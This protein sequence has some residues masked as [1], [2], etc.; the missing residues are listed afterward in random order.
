MAVNLLL[1]FPTAR[2]EQHRRVGARRNLRR[3]YGRGVTGSTY[4][5]ERYAREN[6]LL[7]HRIFPYV[8]TK[9]MA[10][11]KRDATAE[12]HAKSGVRSISTVLCRY[13]KQLL[14]F[15]DFCF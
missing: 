3:Y 14:L 15:G 10:R 2:R 7:F 4:G 11:P 1:D 12:V 13:L 8:V 5:G 6:N 9:I